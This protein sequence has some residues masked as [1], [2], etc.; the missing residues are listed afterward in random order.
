[1]DEI[2]I[3]I[4]KQ[5]AKTNKVFHNYWGKLFYDGLLDEDIE[6][7]ERPLKKITRQFKGYKI[8]S[9]VSSTFLIAISMLNFLDIIALGKMSQIAPFIVITLSTQTSTY[10]F[11]KLKVNLENKIYLLGLLDKIETE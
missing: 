5:I 8:L 3:D 7:L 11:Y 2:K 9:I 1:M 10:T 6:S 4:E